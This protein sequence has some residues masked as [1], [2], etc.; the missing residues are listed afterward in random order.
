MIGKYISHWRAYHEKGEYVEKVLNKFHIK[1]HKNF[2]KTSDRNTSSDNST[3]GSEE[4]GTGSSEGSSLVETPQR[5]T[6]AKKPPAK[7]P[8]QRSLRPRRRLL[9]SILHLLPR[10]YKKKSQ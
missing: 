1:S 7:N 4:A 9:Q 8:L 3:A 10:L 2:K 6:T 5:K